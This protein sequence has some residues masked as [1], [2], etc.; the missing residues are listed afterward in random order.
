MIKGNKCP[1]G[2]SGSCPN[3]SQIKM[4]AYDK[5]DRKTVWYSFFKEDKKHKNK[6]SLAEIMADRYKGFT[7]GYGKIV[8]FY[9]N[10][11]REGEHFKVEHL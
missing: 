10:I 11:N 7:K 9:D 4:V 1:C 5:G 3:H 8:L 6:D 2:K